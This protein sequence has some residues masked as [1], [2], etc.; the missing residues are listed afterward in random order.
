MRPPL[1][2]RGAVWTN[3]LVGPVGESSSR[4]LPCKSSSRSACTW[5]RCSASSDQPPPCAHRA[6]GPPA[7]PARSALSKRKG[8]VFTGRSART[9]AALPASIVRSTMIPRA[10]RAVHTSDAQLT[11]FAIGCA[12]G[13]PRPGPEPQHPHDVARFCIRRCVT[14]GRITARHTK[15]IQHFI[16]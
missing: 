6:S 1:G 14:F 4:R 10:V 9:I 16:T 13:M 12:S 11:S 15:S 5:Y 8:T 7:V 2:A 3:G